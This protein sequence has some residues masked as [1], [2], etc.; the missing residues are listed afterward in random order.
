MNIHVKIYI[1]VKKN[2]VFYFQKH[3]EAKIKYS[4]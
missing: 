3:Q 4:L 2:Q 1:Y